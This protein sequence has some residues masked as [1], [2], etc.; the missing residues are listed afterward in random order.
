MVA[1]VSESD[2]LRLSKGMSATISHSAFE[3]PLSGK[4][5]SIG[6]YVAAN[7]KTANVRIRLEPN[8]LAPRL[9]NME[10]SVTIDLETG[11]SR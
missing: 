11:A 2:L 1:E 3:T 4:V 9:L 6:R 5:E 10:V 8:D 7:V